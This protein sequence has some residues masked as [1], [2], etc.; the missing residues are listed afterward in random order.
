M[1]SPKTPPSSMPANVPGDG[2]GQ[3]LETASRRGEAPALTRASQPGESSGKGVRGE[4]AAQITRLILA[5]LRLK[6]RHLICAEELLLNG[7][8][9]GGHRRVDFWTLAPTESAGFQ[10]VAFEVKASRSDFKRDTDEKQR[11]ARLYSNRFYYVVPEG[12]ID[13]SEV[14]SWAGLMWWRPLEKRPPYGEAFTY[15]KRSPKTDKAE[16]DWLFV[17]TLLRSASS[18]ARDGAR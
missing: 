14:P 2:A 17:A 10:A 15:K 9:F 16:P 18:I 13:R 7:G 12:L 8:V 4:S 1:T 11:W 3:G 6:S 5:D